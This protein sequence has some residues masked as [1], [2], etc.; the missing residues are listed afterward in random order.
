MGGR[1]CPRIV[2]CR[3]SGW[4][5]GFGAESTAG[6]AHAPCRGV[7]GRWTVQLGVVRNACAPCRASLGARTVLFRAIR[8]ARISCLAGSS[9]RMVG[10]LRMALQVQSA[11]RVQMD[12]P[13]FS[14]SQLSGLPAFRALWVRTVGTAHA[15]CRAC[16]SVTDGPIRGEWRGQDNPEHRAMW[17]LVDEWFSSGRT[18]CPVT[19][20]FGWKDGLVGCRWHCWVCPHTVP[21]GFGRTDSPVRGGQECLHFVPCGFGQT[22]GPVG[23]GQNCSC[24]VPYGFGQTDGPVRG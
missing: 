1:H 7:S 18:D 3:S 12:E 9:G 10:S 17:V 24:S 19:C 8:T 15:P 13:V 21:C 22:N 6:T 2:P 4:A 14:G 11:V 5:V 23:G 20:V 16:S